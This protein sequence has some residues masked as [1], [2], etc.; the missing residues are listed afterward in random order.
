MK[1]L[2]RFAVSGLLV[3][4]LAGCGSSAQSSDENKKLEGGMGETLSTMFF[5]VT[6]N[7]A[8][9]TDSVNEVLAG[10]DTTFLVTDITVKNTTSSAIDMAD[11]DFWVKWGD[12]TS[13]YDAPITAYGEDTGLT[14]ALPSKYSL[15]AGEE[16]T[17]K[18]VFVVDKGLSDFSLLT[19]D[20][21]SQGDGEPQKGD[22]YTF[23]FTLE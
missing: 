18:L 11:S 7:D 14:D 5:D 15:A 16:T 2:V 17:G 23:N 9:Q 13:D 6:L 20:Y 19:E 1:N 3:L 10:K 8:Y 4:S 22:T 21:Y 12:G